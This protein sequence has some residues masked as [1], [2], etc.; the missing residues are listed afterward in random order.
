MLN[1]LMFLTQIDESLFLNNC[2]RSFFITKFVQQ[3][4]LKQPN[5]EEHF[6]YVH[7]QN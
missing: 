7:S 5:L 6:K 1:I 2:A 3:F 4:S